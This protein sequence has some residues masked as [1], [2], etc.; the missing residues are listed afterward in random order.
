[1][2]G[3]LSAHAPLLSGF[4]MES[5]DGEVMFFPLESTLINTT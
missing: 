1:V 5:I 3:S 4:L 2:E